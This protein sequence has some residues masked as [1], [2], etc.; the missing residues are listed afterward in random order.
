MECIPRDSTNSLGGKTDMKIW[1]KY[2]PTRVVEL[3]DTCAKK[4]VG[5]ILREY[6]MAFGRDWII[7]AGLKRDEPK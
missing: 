7:W 3:I 1:G 4:D 2:K 6:M 5:Y